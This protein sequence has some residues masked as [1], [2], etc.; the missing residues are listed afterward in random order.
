M[1]VE[2]DRVGGGR[3]RGGVPPTIDDCVA[4][5]LG[6]AFRQQIL[7][8]LNERVAS[9]KEIAKELGET[10]NRVS[11][12]VKVLKEAGC[13]ELVYE[14]PV[15]GAVEHFYQASSR[16]LLEDTAWSD[17]PDSVKVGLRATLLQNIVRGATDSVASETF[18]SY[19]GSHMSWTPMVLDDQGRGELIQV[20]ETALREAIAIQE[21]TQERLASDGAMGVSYAVSILG[22]PSIGGEKRVGPPTDAKSLVAST[23]A[24][25]AKP[26]KRKG[27]QRKSA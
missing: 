12:H 5:V 20:L 14:R 19:E 26:E 16:A 22:Y 21:S 10:L 3:P 18:D 15:G 8:I 27:S 13:I 23:S 6:N 4:K 11:R 24:D 2:G 1:P 25:N 7:W 9:P 17:V